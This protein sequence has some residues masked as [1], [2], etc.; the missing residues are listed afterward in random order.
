MIDAE[1]GLPVQKKLRNA[2]TMIELVFVIVVIGILSAIA[3]PKF[4]GTADT[5]YLT[6][7]QSQLN[8]VRSALATERQKR[9]LRG[10]VKPISDLGD[11]T[12][13]F[14]KFSPDSDNNQSM[15]TDYPLKNCA[16]GQRA[17]WKRIDATHYKYVFPAADIGNDGEAKFKLDKNKLICDNDDADCRL[18]E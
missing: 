5:A 18:I 2:F 15:V 4:S 10:D 9:I 8:V 3:I 12:Y 16:A 11:A 14:N 17:C 6:K 1:K 13:A 7:A